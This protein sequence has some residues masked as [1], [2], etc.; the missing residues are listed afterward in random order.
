MVKHYCP[1]YVYI[2]KQ[3]KSNSVEFKNVLFLNNPW[4]Q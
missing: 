3:Y 1:A 4:S 2:E